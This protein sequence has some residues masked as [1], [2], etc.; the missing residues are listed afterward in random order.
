[1]LIHACRFGFRTRQVQGQLGH[2][3]GILRLCYSRQQKRS[4]GG[5]LSVQCHHAFFDFADIEQVVDKQHDAVGTGAQGAQC[6]V[7]GLAAFSP[8]KNRCG[9]EY[10]RDASPEIMYEH[11]DE[12]LPGP[13][14]ILQLASA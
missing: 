10:R 5:A 3:G 4:Q 12:L 11:I 13:V 14:D 6:L 8:L 9:G 2:G 7:R 1:M